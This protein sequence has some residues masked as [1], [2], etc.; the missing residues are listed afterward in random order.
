MDMRRRMRLALPPGCRFT[1]AEIRDSLEKRVPC[2]I[3]GQIAY[4]WFNSDVAFAKFTEGE[5]MAAQ[6]R[7]MR[8]APTQSCRRGLVVPV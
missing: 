8:R 1:D 5:A 7:H 3:G 4:S 6:K 2:F